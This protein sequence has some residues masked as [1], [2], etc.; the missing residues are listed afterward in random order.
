MQTLYL[1]W[2]SKRALLRAYMEQSLGVVPGDLQPDRP[3]PYTASIDTTSRDPVALLHDIAHVY[4]EIAERAAVGWQLYRDA[5]ASDDEIAADW[6]TLQQL[7]RETFAMLL[8]RFPKTALR[9][10]LTRQDAADTAWAI[11][12]PETYDLLVRRANYTLD[13]YERWV[14]STLITALMGQPPP[15]RGRPARPVP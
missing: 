10:G 12:S 8:A 5:A 4:R 13:R 7:R 9:P 14:G 6:N 1:A 15:P 3:R 2:G 11:A